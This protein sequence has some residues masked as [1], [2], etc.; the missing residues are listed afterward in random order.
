MTQNSQNALSN[1][2]PSQLYKRG[3][4]HFR[5]IYIAC[6]NCR[7]HKARC[8]LGGSGQDI[9]A[10]SGPPCARCRR[11]SRECVFSEGRSSRKRRKIGTPVNGSVN[12]ASLNSQADLAFGTTATQIDRDDPYTKQNSPNKTQHPRGS[13]VP[14]QDSRGFDGQHD[15]VRSSP[16]ASRNAYNDSPDAPV[17]MIDQTGPTHHAPELSVA[18]S[19]EEHLSDVIMRKVITKGNDPI[20]LLFEAAAADAPDDPIYSA[21]REPEQ[22]PYRSAAMFMSPRGKATDLDTEPCTSAT[23]A[24][25]QSSSANANVLSA[26]NLSRCVR[27]G[28][29]VAEEAIFLVDE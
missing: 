26:W 8:E 11:E 17:S 27:M 1:H 16:V 23:G 20:D 4:R 28:F 12:T 5:R 6:E 18:S 9:F 10:F 7:K 21:H 2:D 19:M 3:D 25:V 22:Q 24:N 13:E 15:A 29:L 14:A